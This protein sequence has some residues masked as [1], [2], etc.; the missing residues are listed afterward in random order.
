[1]ILRSLMLENFRQFY[2]KQ[3]IDFAMGIENRNV[4]LIH[5]FN[6]SGKT[7]LL[8][9]FVWCLY[10]ETTPDFGEPKEP[11]R[12]ESERA[13]SEAQ[14]GSTIKVSVQLR[15][16]D[17]DK[18]YVVERLQEVR[19]LG[20][21]EAGR[22]DPVLNMWQVV[23]GELQNEKGD[24]NF[25][26]RLLNRILPADLYP[27]FFFN[28][29]R[30]EA[31]AKAEQSDKVEQGIKVF[32]DVEIYE[33]SMKHLRSDAA[34]VLGDELK[35][36]G[37]AELVAAIEEEQQLK[38]KIEEAEGQIASLDKNIA[39]TRQ[40]IEQLEERQRNVESIAALA[41]DRSR[42]EADLSRHETEKVEV[43]AELAKKLSEDGYLAFAEPTFARTRE[44]VASARDRGELPAKIKPQFVADLLERARCVCGRS[45]DP[46]TDAEEIRELEEWR[47]KVGLADLEEQ[48]GQTFAALAP[49]RK[50]RMDMFEDI[51]QLQAKR[52]RILSD[53]AETKRKLASIEERLGNK[54][55][56]GEDT[57]ELQRRINHLRDREL[58]D[59][60]ADKKKLAEKLDIYRNDLSQNSANQKKLKVQNEKAALVRRQKQAVE[61]I[62]DVLEAIYEL[63]KQEVR[64]SLSDKL[65]KVWSDAAI[66]SYKAS[67]LEDFRL[68]L[69][70]TVGGTEQPVHGAS[71]GEKQVLALAFVGS[72]VQKARENAEASKKNPQALALPIGGHYPLIMDSPFGS[73]EDEYREKVAAW[74]PRLA[75]Q[76]VILVSNTQWRDE[77]ERATRPLIGREYVLELH[78]PKQGADRSITI[79]S[80]AFNYVVESHDPA[81]Q[82]II[83]KVG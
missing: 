45:L 27:F 21:H 80:E 66:K 36:L 70:K 18:D 37:N 78:T 44:L 1:M 47:Q 6:G 65:S 81:E 79:G 55:Q 4:T 12:L 8:N 2:G 39:E 76:V 49:L 69:T 31:L 54:A 11:K 26:Q 68:S 64:Q 14:V 48:I 46:V 74:I 24:A 59:Q 38:K 20:E 42:C 41:E 56:L 30:V 32:L 43:E 53:R 60:V 35:T 71:T 23:N 13:F 15:F 10:G 61:K 3:Q 58:V 82:T 28:G 77:V 83:N 25:K 72:L 16:E 63:Q 40:Q 50:R 57:A 29:E 17:G 62:A 19:K 33:R 5:G 52:D 9:A 73:L 7:T 22:Q 67:L 75:H 51:T 34:K